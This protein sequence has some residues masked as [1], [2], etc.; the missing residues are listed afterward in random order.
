MGEMALNLDMSKA[1][2]RVKWVCL[3]RI[4]EKLSFDEKWR[5]LIMQCVTTVSYS[6][7]INR[8]P[9]GN[10]FPSREIRQGDPLSS[11]LFILYAECLSSLI[12]SL[13]ANGVLEGVAVC[14]G[15]PKLSHLFFVDIA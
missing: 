15:G 11:Y 5:S 3:N 4:M 14:R 13:V 1:Y 6:I 7:R 12:K 2:D 8:L 9:R 10:I